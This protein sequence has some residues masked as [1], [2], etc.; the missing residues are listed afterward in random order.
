MF[1]KQLQHFTKVKN[2]KFSVLS[3]E[4][5]PE[6]VRVPGFAVDPGRAPAAAEVCERAREWRAWRAWS[7]CVGQTH[8]HGL[9]RLLPGCGG[10]VPAV[11][12][13]RVERLELGRVP[14]ICTVVFVNVPDTKA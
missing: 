12:L 3:G 5:Q 11:D 2:T 13:Q 6:V 10:S 7:L 14:I 1:S 4:Q 8:Q 9:L